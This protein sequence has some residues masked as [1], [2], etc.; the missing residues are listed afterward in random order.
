MGLSIHFSG[1]LR[2]ADYLPTMIEEIKD[3]SN[4]YGWKYHIFDTR[5]P[6]DAFDNHTS[7]ENVYGINF[8][9]TN[10][11]TISLVFL[12]NGVMVFPAYISLFANS[13]KEIERNFIYTNSV[14]TQFAGVFMHQ[15]IIRLFKH[16]NAK[17]FEDFKLNDESYYWETDDENL[18]RERF[19]VY[20]SLLD[21]FE[22]SIQT[23]PIESGENIVA[24]F[25]RLMRH[26][27]SLKKG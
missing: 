1:R 13:E 25:E 2:K 27:D 4:V 22:L 21:N 19:K 17:Y 11:E 15:L 10:C 24:Y 20:D 14:K 18:M 16:L 23:F 5:F 8:T 6:N 9:P 12:S 3:I 26:I 7:F